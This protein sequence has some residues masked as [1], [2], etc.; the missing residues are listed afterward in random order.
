MPCTTLLVGKK[1]TI[2]GSTII[3]RTDDGFFDVKKIIVV[4]PDKQPKKYKSKISGVEV[5]L[6][7]NPM[8][9][10]AC[11]SVDPKHGIWAATGINAANVGMTATETI[12]S[13]PRVLGADPCHKMVNG[14]P[15]GIGEEDLVVL[16]LPYIKTAREGVLRLG[17]LLEQY[18]TYEQNGIA[19]NDEND[20]WWLESIGG[21]HWIARRVPE[22]K[23]VVMPNQFGLDHFDWEDALGEGKDFLC[24]KDLKE[25]VEKNHLDANN[26][27]KF[28]PRL[29]FGSHDDSD[30]VYNTPRGWYMCRYFNPRTYK[31]DGPD[32]D[33]TPESDDIPWS[34]VPERKIAVEEVK[35]ILSSYYQGTPYNPYAHEDTGVRGKYRPIGVNRTGVTGIIQIRNN[36]PDEVKG[37]EWLCFGCNAFNAALPLYTNVSKMPKYVS[38][39]T[40][41]V[42]TESFYWAT[43]LIGNMAD[44]HYGNSIIFVERYQKAVFNKA[45]EILNEYDAKIAET[46]DVKLIEEANEKLAKMCKAESQKVLNSLTLECSKG[47]KTGYARSD[48]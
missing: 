23:Y 5:E 7:D 32:A 16:T 2:D 42:T 6:P 41:D 4:E 26:D 22:N 29:V 28:N 11:P 40:L 37:V 43:R 14:K 18:G 12:T 38:N 8:R 15:V 17:A 34:L 25:F 31:W 19:F 36:V 44:A 47:M 45:R 33:F 3:A 39:T 48:N 21:H 1:A 35:H 27:G 9:Y 20:I 46:K 24:S 30:H 13:N 10:T